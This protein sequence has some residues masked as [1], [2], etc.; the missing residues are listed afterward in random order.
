M[1]KNSQ[2]IKENKNAKIKFTIGKDG[3]YTLCKLKILRDDLSK[4]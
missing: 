4:E 3:F 1:K 2:L